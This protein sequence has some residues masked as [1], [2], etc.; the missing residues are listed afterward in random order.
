M[1]CGTVEGVAN[2]M[3]ATNTNVGTTGNTSGSGMPP[4]SPHLRVT[5]LVRRGYGGV[6]GW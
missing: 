2:V 1:S 6:D 5:C 3:V 4:T